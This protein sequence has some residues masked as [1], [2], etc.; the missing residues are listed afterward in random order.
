[1]T[2]RVRQGLAALCVAA[3]LWIVG[4]ALGGLAAD[5]LTF[6]AAVAAVLA[7]AAIAVALVRD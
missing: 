2:G 4:H 6:A 5:V 3:A 1:M 7:L